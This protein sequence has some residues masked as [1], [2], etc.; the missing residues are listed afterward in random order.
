M[1]DD[2]DKWPITCPECGRI[3]DEEIGR[4]KNT[5]VFTCGRCGSVFDVNVEAVLEVLTNLQ[6]TFKKV[7]STT[8]IL[9][10]RN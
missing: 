5:M 8:R 4:L 2:I 3:T 10:K 6:E 7:A 1:F 9:S